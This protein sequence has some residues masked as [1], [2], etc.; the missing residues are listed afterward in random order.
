MQARSARYAGTAALAAVLLLLPLAGKLN[1]VRAAG[2][3]DEKQA[4]ILAHAMK[5]SD[6]MGFEVWL[7]ERLVYA[8]PNSSSEMRPSS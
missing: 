8:R 2:S 1:R 3:A 7:D 6:T 5:L 4:K